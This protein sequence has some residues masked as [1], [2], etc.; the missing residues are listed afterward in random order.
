MARRASKMEVAL[1]IFPKGFEYSS[2]RDIVEGLVFC[3][4]SNPAFF[5]SNIP[6][7][8]PHH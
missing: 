6:Y 3:F 5:A 2:L 7:Y 4:P 1:S 8:S